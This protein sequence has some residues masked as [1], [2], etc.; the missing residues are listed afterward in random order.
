MK[1]LRHQIRNSVAEK[2]RDSLTI[3]QANIFGYNGSGWYH[4]FLMP[5][6]TIK[7]WGILDPSSAVQTFLE[8][9]VECGILRKR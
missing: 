3:K 5:N 1:I 2:V 6:Q 9:L 8:E 4:K 7:T